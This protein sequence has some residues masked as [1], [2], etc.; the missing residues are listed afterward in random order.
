[1]E[2]RANRD[3]EIGRMLEWAM[4][5]PAPAPPADLVARSVEAVRRVILAGDLLR[6]ATLETL[7]SHAP[8]RPSGRAEPGSAGPEDAS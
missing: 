1:M 6:F 3:R 4:S 7:W 8:A 5:E 2:D